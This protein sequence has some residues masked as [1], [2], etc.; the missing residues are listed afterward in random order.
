MAR[1]E[2]FVAFLITQLTSTQVRVFISSGIDSLLVSKLRLAMF[3]PN[4]LF[5]NSPTSTDEGN[6]AL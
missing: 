3:T 6:G 5:G 1:D 4:T 2:A